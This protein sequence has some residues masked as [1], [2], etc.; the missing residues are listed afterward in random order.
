MQQCQIHVG[1]KDGVN[2]PPFVADHVVVWKSDLEFVSRGKVVLGG[3]FRREDVRGLTINGHW[4]GERQIP[5]ISIQVVDTGPVVIFADD[6][7]S[8]DWPAPEWPG[9][10]KSKS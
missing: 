9:G 8:D 4:E 7:Q 2:P 1:L 10:S 6:D 3:C 5:G